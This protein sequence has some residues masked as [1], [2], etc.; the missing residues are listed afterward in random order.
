MS[1]H[2]P[3]PWLIDEFYEPGGFYKIRARDSALCLIH[4][5]AESGT[6][7]EAEANARL[8]AAAPDLLEAVRYTIDAAAFDDVNRW[9]TALGLLHA[10]CA[11]AEGK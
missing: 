5:I 9:S 3:A 1:K 11:K 10:A 8:I 4:S 7:P 6:D 2:T